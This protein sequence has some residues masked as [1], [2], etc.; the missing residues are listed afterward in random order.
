MR[1]APK[2]IPPILL[3]WSLTSEAAVGMTVEVESSQTLLHFVAMWQMAAEGHSDKLVS[4]VEVHVKKR[5]GIEFLHAE[6]S[7]TD[8]D[9]HSL[10]V[11]GVQTL[12]V[13]TVRW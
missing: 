2:V 8:I 3:C 12:N 7:S 9:Q 5:G 11:Y 10:N 6:N 13:S 1:D 4:H